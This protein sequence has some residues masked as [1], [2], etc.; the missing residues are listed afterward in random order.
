MAQQF[1]ELIAQAEDLDSVPS[2]HT[3]A[4]NHL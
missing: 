3:E 1:R 4:H 2:T